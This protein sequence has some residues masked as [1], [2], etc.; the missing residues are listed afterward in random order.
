MVSR[1]LV[2]LLSLVVVASQTGGVPEFRRSPVAAEIDS[3]GPHPWVGIYEHRLDSIPEL[4]PLVRLELSPRGSYVLE[5]RVGCFL[6]PVITDG[7]VIA[8]DGR[9]RLQPRLPAEPQFPTVGHDP[10]PLAGGLLTLA[11]GGRR[12]LIPASQVTNFCNA[13]NSGYGLSMGGGLF[14]L[15][16]GEESPEAPR[17]ELPLEVSRCLLEKPLRTRIV[18]VGDV[19]GHGPGQSL[20][21]STRRRGCPSSC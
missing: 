8:D 11:L 15:R 1:G 16:E 7:V 18:S 2:I 5:R 9:I 13:V 12:Y 19:E 17:E 14:L 6:T 3:P 20:P 10:D 4:G 21:G